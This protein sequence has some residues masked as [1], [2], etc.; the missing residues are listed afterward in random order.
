MASQKKTMT[1]LNS[2]LLQGYS[3]DPQAYT[4]SVT[5]KDGTDID[6]VNVPPP[7]VSKVF[8]TPGSVGSKFVKHIAKAGYRF[9][10]AQP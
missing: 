7:V 3:Y 8:D 10:K 5:F 9:V 4:L 6:Y 1:V 2:T